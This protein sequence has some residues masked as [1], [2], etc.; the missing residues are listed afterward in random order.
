MNLVKNKKV[1][2]VIPA[3]AGSKGIE[4]KNYRTINNR[5]LVYWS[6]LAAEKSSC[7]TDVVVTT[8]C[9][10]VKEIT[11]EFNR[12]S[13]KD[14]HIVS[15]P[16][17]LCAD[18]SP[19]EDAILHVLNHKKYKNIDDIILLQPTSPSRPND[20]INRCYKKYVYQQNKCLFTADEYSPFFW[21]ID[22]SLKA[23]PLCDECIY[24]PMRQDLN[25]ML[26]HDNGNIYIVDKKFFLQHKNRL[27]SGSSVS[28][29]IT[30]KFESIQIDTEEDFL[31]AEKATDAF[32]NL[33]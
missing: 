27:G 9:D 31:F 5:P 3:R 21:A 6:L 18:D 26:Y 32:G 2:A 14:V 30:N 13:Y 23:Y 7:I 25:I 29:F 17:H 11:K 8:N 15:R 12:T 19:T 20:L 33:V 10:T 16:E 28:I 4:G 22:T 24:R 1:L